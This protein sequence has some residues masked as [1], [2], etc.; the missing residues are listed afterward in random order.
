MLLLSF[1][2]CFALISLSLT[3]GVHLS[4]SPR[5]N[6][7]NKEVDDFRANII[8]NAHRIVKGVKEIITDFQKSQILKKKIKIGGEKSLT[9]SEFK[10]LEEFG[11]DTSKLFRL[12][13]TIPLSPE[14]FF[15]SYLVFPM[16]FSGNNPFAW[17]AFPSTFGFPEEE[18]SR[19]AIIGKRRIQMLVEGVQELKNTQVEVPEQSLGSVNKDSTNTNNMDYNIKLIEQALKCNDIDSS[20]TVFEPWYAFE[21]STK[22]NRMNKK[23]LPPPQKAVLKNIPWNFAKSFCRS[24][25]M[26]GLPNVFFIRR[27]N[28]G[29]ISKYV[30][31]VRLSDKHISLTGVQSLNKDELELAC[32]ERCISTRDGISEKNMRNDLTRYL[33]I[34]NS[35]TPDHLR[36]QNKAVNEQNRR[37]A[38]MGLF[39]HRDF[40]KSD[41]SSTYRTLSGKF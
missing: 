24:C 33:T 19:K 37:L 9:F 36:N 40:L 10:F 39:A 13:I 21:E 2:I 32:Y 16:L 15:Y 5:F 20:M 34:V 29:E 22:I 25:G 8:K 4:S 35:P 14:F 30:D 23:K 6:L 18:I 17:N 11:K 12:L 38:L 27:M 7:R 3:S 1:L 26:D 28:L 31:Q 41:F